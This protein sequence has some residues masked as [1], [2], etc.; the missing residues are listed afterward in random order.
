[1]DHPPLGHSDFIVMPSYVMS[2]GLILLTGPNG[3]DLM[4]DIDRNHASMCPIMGMWIEQ[5]LGNQKWA[6]TIG[7]QLF[8]SS[9]VIWYAMW[10]DSPNRAI[11]MR[12]NVWYWYQTF[13]DWSNTWGVDE[14]DHRGPEMDHTPLYRSY[15]IVMPSY[16][17]L[18]YV[19]RLSLKGP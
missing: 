1:M 19:A 16:V 3:W 18:C 17:M 8:G 2:C 9:A 15:M 7:P 5:T 13:I 12:F 4:S 10:L 14:T 11:W 6:P